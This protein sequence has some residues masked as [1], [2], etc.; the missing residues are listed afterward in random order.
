MNSN[1]LDLHP[2]EKQQLPLHGAAEECVA[3]QV[4]TCSQGGTTARD[5]PGGF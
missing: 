2:V 5:S 3:A 1:L 4:L